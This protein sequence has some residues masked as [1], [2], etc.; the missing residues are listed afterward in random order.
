MAD[1]LTS[2]PKNEIPYQCDKQSPRK[3]INTRAFLLYSH[4]LIVSRNNDLAEMYV[5]IQIPG[6]TWVIVAAS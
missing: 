4:L 2:L 5:T 1:Y 6:C 3:V